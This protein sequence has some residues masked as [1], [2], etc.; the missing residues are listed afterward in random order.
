VTAPEKP[1]APPGEP[2]RAPLTHVRTWII[3]LVVVGVGAAITQAVTGGITSAGSSLWDRIAGEPAPLTVDAS[4]ASNDGTAFYFARPAAELGAVPSPDLGSA[5]RA[6]WARALGGA[7]ASSTVVE[8]VVQGKSSTAVVL[9]GLEVRVRDRRPPPGGTVVRPRGGEAVAVRHFS[10]DLDPSPAAVSSQPSDVPTGGPDAAIDFPY[11]VSASE[12]EVF[13][14]LARTASCDCDWT[15]ELGWAAGGRRGVTT[16]DDDGMPFRTV[17][18]AAAV[19]YV[20]EE[21]ALVRAE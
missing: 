10:I 12:P 8:V 16:I 7:N 17:S 20:E 1:A 4:V 15:A 11:R 18:A 13:L 2:A 14:L 19:D 3:G 21:G 6:E 5:A 9:T